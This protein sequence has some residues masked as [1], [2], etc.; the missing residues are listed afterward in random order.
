[1][2]KYAYKIVFFILVIT[3]VHAQKNEATKNDLTESVTKQKFY[4]SAKRAGLTE[5]KTKELLKIID[6]RNQVLKELDTKKKQANAP[7]SIQDPGT[8]YNFKINNARNYYARKINTSLTYKEYFD[9]A[10][11]DYVY[12]AAE[13]A[14]TEYQQLI[15][16][17]TNLDENQKKRLGDLIYNYHL[18]QLL[19]SAYYCYDKALQKP[20]TGILRFKFEKEFKK[21]C[22]E[23]NIK[24]SGGGEG[25]TNGFEWN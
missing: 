18:N 2:K 19:T 14:K 11:E 4:E 20:K 25:N 6:E 5:V 15:K 13:N 12:E 7:Y 22:T 3:G 24:T 9:F 8:L 1:M 21:L 23:Y 10:A 17:N 16:S